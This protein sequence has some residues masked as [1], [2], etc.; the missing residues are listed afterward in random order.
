M[1]RLRTAFELA[2]VVALTA[3]AIILVSQDTEPAAGPVADTSEMSYNRQAGT[4]T[5]PF[6]EE[7]LGK[8]VLYSTV[9]LGCLDEYTATS[10]EVFV[11]GAPT[12]T[13]QWTSPRTCKD[14]VMDYRDFNS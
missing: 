11:S 13:R 7:K 14:L 9:T 2:P 6:Y 8:R 4:A 5:F 12:D 10:A 3:G 1:N